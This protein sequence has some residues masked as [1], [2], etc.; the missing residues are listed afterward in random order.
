MDLQPASARRRAGGYTLAELMTV[1]AILAIIAGLALPS[2]MSQQ[3]RSRRTEA[4][5]AVLD[6]AGRQERLY[7]TTNAYSALPADLGY[8]AA[9]ATFPMEVGSGYYRVDVKL[10]DSPPSF[11]ITAKPVTGKGQDQDT[12]CASFSV[13]NTGKHSATSSSGADTSASCWR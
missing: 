5:T 13:T 11:T 3:R 9:N 2:Y 10:A 6:L 8:G 4:R 1:M 12:L 7:S